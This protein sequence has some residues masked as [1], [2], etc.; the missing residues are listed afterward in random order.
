[1]MKSM[2]EIKHLH[3]QQWDDLQKAKRD[4]A[5][6]ETIPVFVVRDRGVLRKSM[7]LAVYGKLPK[8]QDRIFID[9]ERH[10]FAKGLLYW[11][12]DLGGRKEIVRSPGGGTAYQRLV[13]GRMEDR[14]IGYGWVLSEESDIPRS[15]HTQTSDSTLASTSRSS[16]RYGRARTE[17]RDPDDDYVD[18]ICPQRPRTESGQFM[19][20]AST[21]TSNRRGL[22][23]SESR[24]SQPFVGDRR[25]EASRAPWLEDEELAVRD[26]TEGEID[27]FCNDADNDRRSYRRSST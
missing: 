3:L 14:T 19:S 12:A 2:A 17:N 24:R 11:T 20:A 6:D 23:K 10:E 13:D 26:S 8:E 5:D 9:L 27:E 15:R 16:S 1:M 21:G 22:N 25:T 4:Y 7:C 18:T